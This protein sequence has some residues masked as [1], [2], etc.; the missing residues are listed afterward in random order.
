MG[1]PAWESRERKS[2]VANPQ[3]TPLSA[4]AAVPAPQLAATAGSDTDSVADLESATDMANWLQRQYLQP[5]GRKT[6]PLYALGPSNS[7]LLVLSDCDQQQTV[8][9]VEQPF[10]GAAGKLLDAMLKA[11]GLSRTSCQ[12]AALATNGQ[13]TLQAWCAQHEPRVILYF[14][15]PN[16]SQ[17]ARYEPGD[18]ASETTRTQTGIHC[19]V[20]YHP[21]H[22]LQHPEL[23]RR[24]WE[25][26][27]AVRR[28]LS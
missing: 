19:V 14:V 22:L 3:A 23:K 21:E 13:E 25:D 5:L 1:I 6:A 12:L 17:P 27:K 20:S 4:S 24:A 15:R 7:D 9:P 18:S 8:Q 28:L 16:S 11:I 26:L 2:A 10:L